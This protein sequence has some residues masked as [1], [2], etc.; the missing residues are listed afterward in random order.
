[1]ERFQQYLE[2]IR[3]NRADAEKY[4]AMGLNEVAQAFDSVVLHLTIILQGELEQN[5]HVQTYKQ[6][7]ERKQ[8]LETAIVETDNNIVSYEGYQEVQFYKEI[9]ATF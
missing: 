9:S 4:R 3:K 6:L 5:T 8:Q 1:M 7:I 2:D